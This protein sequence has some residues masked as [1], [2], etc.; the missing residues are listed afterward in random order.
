MYHPLSH[1]LNSVSFI[2]S[3]HPTTNMPIR[4]FP[5]CVRTWEQCPGHGTTDR[6]SSFAQPTPVTKGEHHSSSPP[7]PLRARSLLVWTE[8][9]GWGR[10]N[11]EAEQRRGAP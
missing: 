5:A 2:S 7:G 11:E 9:W 3:H 4:P 1:V 8:T 10:R 6:K